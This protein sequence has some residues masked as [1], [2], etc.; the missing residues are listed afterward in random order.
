MKNLVSEELR[1][2]EGLTT[3]IPSRS[4]DTKPTSSPPHS[5]NNT[6]SDDDDDFEDVPDKEGF[7]LEALAP[8][9]PQS[10]SNA[11]KST[12]SFTAA[13]STSTSTSWKLWGREEEAN[14]PTTLQATLRKKMETH[15]EKHKTHE[16]SGENFSQE[17][18]A[19]NPSSF[20]GKTSERKE[21]L[22]RLAPKLP[23]DIDLYHWEDKD[24]KAP[25][26]QM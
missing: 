1:R 20:L 15:K 18:S 16:K 3:I 5:T 12:K 26:I 2:W 24:L 7:E 4:L 22:L 10:S 8:P 17:K 11:D 21:R 25:A 9:A 14:D 6:D 13:V 23:F 19:E